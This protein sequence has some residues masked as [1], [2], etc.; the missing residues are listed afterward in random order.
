VIQKLFSGIDL[1]DIARFRELNPAIRERFYARVFTQ[2]EKAYIGRSFERAAGIFA[3]KEA[4]VKA[5][6]CGIGLV[7]WQEVA[8]GYEAQGK[9]MPELSGNAKA[10]EQALDISEWSVSISHTKSSAVAVAVAYSKST[11]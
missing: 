1:V 11:E 2:K 5:L 3:A 9:P 8:I 4:L 7:S 6:G 10:A